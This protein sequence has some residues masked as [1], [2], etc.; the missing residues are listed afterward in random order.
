MS[1]HVGVSGPV[2]MTMATLFKLTGKAKTQPLPVGLSC[3]VPKHFSKPPWHF[4]HTWENKPQDNTVDCLTVYDRHYTRSPH[5]SW[6]AVNVMSP[7]ERCH[8]MSSQQFDNWIRWLFFVFRDQNL[9][10][11]NKFVQIE[12]PVLISGIFIVIS[13][14]EPYYKTP[15]LF[16]KCRYSVMFDM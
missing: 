9:N 15:L 8:F 4:T 1:K 11:F 14:V 6:V 7:F 2:Y 5:T 3:E 13:R 10:Y 12:D 16:Y